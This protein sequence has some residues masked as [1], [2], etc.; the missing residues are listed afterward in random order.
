MS[1]FNPER[2]EVVLGALATG[3]ALWLARGISAE[4]ATRKVS[5]AQAKYQEQ[6]KG[7]QK[8]ANCMQYIADSNSCKLVDGKISSTAWCT[9]W[10]KKQA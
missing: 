8:C 7:D 6:P 4:I 9:L 3:C 1:T 2:R 10:T 5:K